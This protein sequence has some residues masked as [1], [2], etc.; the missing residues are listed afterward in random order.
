MCVC[1]CMCVHVCVCVCVHACSLAFLFPKSFRQFHLFKEQWG[2]I[3]I[4]HG[5][6]GLIG[7]SVMR[8]YC[9]ASRGLLRDQTVL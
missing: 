9:L 7:K 6:E 3:R 8:V 4:Y 1:V 5:F 2:I